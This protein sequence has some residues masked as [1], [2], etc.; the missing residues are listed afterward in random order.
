MKD[1]IH[2]QK[3]PADTNANITC[4]IQQINPVCE[5]YAALEKMCLF[6][7]LDDLTRDVLLLIF[8]LFPS[9][10]VGTNAGGGDVLTQTRCT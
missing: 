1:I 2:G 5:T 6:P 4:D 8:D 7:L 10:S 9:V 3:R